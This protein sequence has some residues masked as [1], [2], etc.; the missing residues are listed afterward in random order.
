MPRGARTRQS[1]SRLLFA[2]LATLCAAVSFGAAMPAVSHADACTPPVANPVACENS[3]PGAD[4]RTWQIDGAG[5]AEI[6]GFATSQ[7]VTKG[8]TISFK[9][10]STTSDFHIDIF[11]LG[12]YGEIG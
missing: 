4:P 7:S 6:Q 5:D 10:N 12:Y 8:D 11:R 1:V 9:I 3:L 2:G